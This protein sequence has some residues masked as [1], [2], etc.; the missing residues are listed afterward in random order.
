MLLSKYLLPT[1]KEIPREVEIPSHQLMIRSGIMRQLASGIY[2]WLPLGLRVVH[3]VEDIVREEMNLI[4]G[5]E[6][7][8]PAM[9]PRE[10]W[11]ESG[12]WDFYGKELIRLKDRNKRDFC[13]GPT[14]EEVITDLVRGEVRSYKELPLLL[15][16]FQTKF[17]DEIRPRFGVIRAREFYM[18]DAY[19]F[20][21]TDKNAETSYNNV[22]GAYCKIFQRCGLKFRSVEAQTGAIGGTFSH[23]FMVIAEAGEEIMVSC[24]C[25]YAAN[26]E[27]AECLPPPKT[28]RKRSGL[29]KLEE[30]ETKDMKTV[31]EVGKFLKE[32]PDKFIKTLVY[33][34]DSECVIVMIRGDH[35]VNESKVKSYLGVNEIFL[36]DEKTIEEVTGA[37]LGFA[38]PVGLKV[39]CK[40]LADY[41]VEG[42]VNGITGANKKDYHLRNV[43]MSRDFEV[44]KV[45]DLRKVKEG[46]ACPKCGKRL[47]FS[48]GIEVGHTFKLGTKYSEALRA[49]F[50]DKQGK[51]KYF[52]MGCYGIGVSRI[53][54]AAIEQSHDQHGIIWPL[55]IAPFQVLILPVNYEH[56]KTRAI[57]DRIYEQ[58]ESAGQEVLM[59]D[60]D[61]RAGVKFKDADLI[62]IP[63]RVTV[64][65][66]TLAKNM[67]ELKLRGEKEVREIQP[68]Q[69]QKLITELMKEKED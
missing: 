15:Y 19:S 10:L 44:D 67:V 28:E 41:S 53:V 69:V 26:L 14:H 66:K 59:D 22:F 35:E 61:E 45:L 46:D 31:G 1:L 7:S 39:K 18:K 54:A 43:N 8:L 34:I 13:L 3:K 47:E 52:V 16:Q 2:E 68:D 25:G 33:K 48:R 21:A 62:G 12:R 49:T 60:R 37:P 36:A 38:G 64:G 42:I 9:Q 40:L 32:K 55:P 17:R 50:L 20:D 23:E 63:I 24:K 56:E 51:E 27:K 65:E 4:G 58:L 29:K 57:S 6:V 11:E 30:V 5:Q